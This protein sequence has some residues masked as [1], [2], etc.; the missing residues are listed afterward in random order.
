MKRYLNN[1]EKNEAAIIL[2]FLVFLEKL[3]E[4]QK[5]LK[6]PTRWYKMA[7][8]FLSKAINET[9]EAL[10]PDEARLARKNFAK[11]NLVL[12][13][14][15]ETLQEVKNMKDDDLIVP[16][17]N[18]DFLTLASFALGT[19]SNCNTS[20]Y[21]TCQLREIFMEYEVEPVRLNTEGCQY[22]M[23]DIKDNACFNLYEVDH[24]LFRVQPGLAFPGKL[25]QNAPLTEEHWGKPKVTV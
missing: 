7:T 1:Q 25:V 22:N 2:N 8:S 9:F 19:C 18:D 3:V 24:M 12:K 13:T 11:L 4:K 14:S 23:N 6:R 20:K 15:K 5:S 21:R 10:D 16:L 17:K